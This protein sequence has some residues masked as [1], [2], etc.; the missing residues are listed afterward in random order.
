MNKNKKSTASRSKKDLFNKCRDCFNIRAKTSENYGKLS[1]SVSYKTL[2][3]GTTTA[4][5]ADEQNQ[6]LSECSAG[7][8]FCKTMRFLYE[9]LVDSL[10]Q[11]LP[12]FKKVYES[13]KKDLIGSSNLI[14]R[15]LENFCKTQKFR[16]DSLLFS[17]SP[18]G[19]LH[20]HSEPQA[21]N[22]EKP[23]NVIPDLIGYLSRIKKE[24]AEIP[25]SCSA[26]PRMTGKALSFLARC[27]AFVR[28]GSLEFGVGDFIAQNAAAMLKDKEAAHCVTDVTAP[29]QRSLDEVT[30][31]ASRGMT[32]S[33][34]TLAAVL[35]I[36]NIS[37]SKAVVISCVNGK[38]ADGTACEK[39]GNACNWSFDTTSG[40]LSVT[41]SGEMGK[42]RNN[43]PPWYDYSEQIKS[44]EVS[45]LS[46]ISDNSFAKLTN[47]ESV[48]ISNSV[49]KIGN[50]AF[51]N[52]S[53]LTN[54]ELPE[55]LT[56]I[57]IFAFAGCKNLTLVE[58]PNS[59]ER[60][61][62]YAF[63]MSGLASI[64]IPEHVKYIGGGALDGTKIKTLTIPD[65]VEVIDG[66]FLW[67]T[68]SIEEIIIPDTFNPSN[69]GDFLLKSKNK[70]VPKIICQGD[71]K[72][73]KENMKHYQ[74]AD[75]EVDMSAYVFAPEDETKCTNKYVWDDRTGKCNRMS[76]RQCNMSGKYYFDGTTC[77]TRKING[78]I[79]C[80]NPSYKEND[81]YCDRIRYTPA[82]AAQYLKDT[83]NEIIMT[84]KVN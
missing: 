59:L 24:V 20:R 26:S 48:K 51:D 62:G 73:C 53:G 25:G 33:T 29:E 10:L 43:N 32:I 36:T 71:I 72:K 61:D 17:A 83:N 38:Y 12:V 27:S 28:Q 1:K 47:N 65:S 57:G 19:S 30:R 4:G 74:T 18:H 69:S 50:N 34:L 37:E 81:G 52:N 22:P 55:N 40:K 84:F 13:R 68:A 79:T 46:K 77:V 3:G 14:R 8:R 56:R 35:S 9:N 42:I 80:T 45:G 21:K 41:G 15:C 64:T 82:E 76:E 63:R 75:G 54:V 60:I 2:V 78:K 7:Y 58:L 66:S 44:V 70:Y 5:R 6:F 49:T 23:K 39:C 67:T 11:M 16:H 31:R